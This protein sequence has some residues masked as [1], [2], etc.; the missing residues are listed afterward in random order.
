MTEKYKRVLIKEDTDIRIEEIAKATR[1]SKIDVIDLAV[2][3]Y[4][5]DGEL[6][7]QKRVVVAKHADGR[8]EIAP[9]FK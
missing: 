5:V 2:A 6:V 4:P 7:N 8:I 3:A 1:R 9:D